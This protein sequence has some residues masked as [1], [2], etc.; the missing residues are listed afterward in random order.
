[1]REHIPKLFAVS[2]NEFRTSVSKRT[3]LFVCLT[4]FALSFFTVPKSPELVRELGGST[5]LTAM[6]SSVAI[7][8]PF[9][10]ATFGYRA[11]VGERE[12]GTI[13]ILAGTQLSRSNLVLG[14]VVGQ[15]V[16]TATSVLPGVLL[17]VAIRAFQYR[18]LAPGLTLALLLVVLLYIVAVVCIVVSFSTLASSSV[19]A[20]ALVFVTTVGGLVLWSD[21]MVPIVWSAVTGS[22][23]GDGLRYPA[24]FEFVTR[25]SPTDSYYVL[26]NWVMGAPI[27]TESAVNQLSSSTS[28]TANSVHITPW[29]SFV[30]LVGVPI[31]LTTVALWAFNRRSIVMQSNDPFGWVPRLTIPWNRLSLRVPLVGAGLSTHAVDRLPGE[32]QPIARREFRILSRTPSIWVLG[33]LVFVSGVLG[34]SVPRVFQTRLGPLVPL[35]TLQTPGITLL[36]GWGIVIST[37]RSVLT[38]RHSGTIRLATGAKPSR[39]SVLFGV[40]VGRTVAFIIPIVVATLLTCA[41]ATPRYGLVSPRA[42][43]GFLLASFGYLLAMGSIGVAISVS[44]RRQVV[45]GGVTVMFLALPFFWSLVTNRLYTAVTGRAVDTLSPPADATYFLLSWMMPTNLFRVLTNQL[46]NTPNSSGPALAV[47]TNVLQPSVTTNIIML[48]SVFGTDVPVWYLHPGIGA[49]GLMLWFGISLAF[50]ITVF[51]NIDLD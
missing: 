49:V 45:V 37:F 23:P 8:V 30:P 48:R 29:F 32:W 7:L 17:A 35:A 24:T 16:A 36:G 19:Q 27:G 18:T 25:L 50:A 34:L 51:N 38:E 47:L 3:F 22:V 46:L 1:M 31:G 40:V 28:G 33:G 5:P 4:T 12:S 9:V 10:A 21:I 20:A 42:L 26:S 41:V 43:L 44:S 15:T 2:R 13:R 14:K 39:A 6:Q 11:V